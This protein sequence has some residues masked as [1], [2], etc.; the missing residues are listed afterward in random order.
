[1]I[2]DTCLPYT[3]LL[4]HPATS[5]TCS[6]RDGTYTNEVR[7]LF[8]ILYYVGIQLARTYEY[9]PSRPLKHFPL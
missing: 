5:T 9:C 7:L 6:A 2:D 3:N 1:M 4:A 8:W